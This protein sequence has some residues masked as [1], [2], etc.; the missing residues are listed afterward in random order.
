M[1]IAKTARIS[2]KNFTPAIRH[3]LVN[4][5]RWRG[6][7]L[8]DG[9]RSNERVVEGPDDIQLEVLNAADERGI[10]VAIVLPGWKTANHRSSGT[11][12]IH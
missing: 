1:Q 5:K 4:V 9:V 12:Q 7:P 2:R 10:S 11:D 8:G 6:V 3:Y